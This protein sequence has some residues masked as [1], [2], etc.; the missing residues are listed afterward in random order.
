MSWRLPGLSHSVEVH[1]SGETGAR[2]WKL[3]PELTLGGILASKEWDRVV[4]VA[5]V[6]TGHLQK[7]KVREIFDAVPGVFISHSWKDA[8]LQVGPVLREQLENRMRELVWYDAQMMS[9]E[10]Q[11]QS[12]M[13]E[14]VTKSWVVFI[15]LSREALA[16]GNCLREICMAR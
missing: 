3:N 7:L 4:R 6:A 5:H 15:L 14:G 16:S 11:F 10:D 2:V 13:A 1:F 9:S 12:R 8:S